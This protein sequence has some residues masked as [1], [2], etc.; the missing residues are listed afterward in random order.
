MK[1]DEFKE[2]FCRRLFRTKQVNPYGY[3]PVWY[4]VYDPRRTLE[5]QNFRRA[6]A[7]YLQNELAMKPVMFS[8]AENLWSLLEQ[9]ENWSDLQDALLEME[10]EGEPAGHEEIMESLAA[11]LETSDG[12]NLLV[13]RLRNVLDE[14]GKTPGAVVLVSGFEALHGLMRPGSMELRLN[15]SFTSP[16]V[17]FYPGKTSGTTG[18]QFLNFYPVDGNYRSEH[19]NVP[20]V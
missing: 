2:D 13:E 19:L 8:V 12:K 4:L 16:T 7:G 17:F 15:G 3:E 11:L 9:N 1:L 20:E 10:A 18:L 5:M 6:L 14:A